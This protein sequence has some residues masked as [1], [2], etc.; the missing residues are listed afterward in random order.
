MN[1]TVFGLMSTLVLSSFSLSAQED[2]ATRATSL[3]EIVITATR[4]P[5]KVSE[6]GKVVTVIDKQEIERSNGKDMAQLLSEQAG[7][8]V[9]GAYSNPGKDKSLYLRG[10]GTDYTVILVN[11]IPVSDPSGTGGAFDV[12]MFPLEQIERIEILKGA[13]STLY[14]SDAVAGVINIITK[15]PVDKPAQLYGG[16]AA[17]SYNTFKADIG[18]NGAGEGSSY[19][20]GFTHYQTAG[21]S[22]A[23]DTTS[24]QTFDKDGFTRNAFL[25]DFDK[26]IARGLHL[27]PYF[28]YT[29]FTGDYDGGSFTDADSKYEAQLLTAG[30]QLQYSFANGSIHAYYNYDEVNR[31]FKDTY[32]EYPYVGSK[33]SVELYAHYSF[34]PHIQLLGGIHYNKQR[35]QDEAA[36]PPNPTA[37]LTSP[38]LS[39]FLRDIGGFNLELGSR[40]NK[41]SAYGNNFTYTVNPSYT[42]NDA[43]KI[44][45]NYATAFKTP[46]LQSL[47]GPF[48]SNPDLAPETSAT[49]EAGIQSTLWS[50]VLDARLVY[51]RRTIDNV[52]I[53]GP[54]F[55]LINLNKQ[56]DHGFELEP[57][58]YIGKQLKLKLYYAFVDGEVTTEQNG[59]DS[60]YSNLIRRPKHS[61]GLNAGWEVTPRFFLST[62]INYNGRRSDLYYDPITYSSQSAQLGAYTLWNAYASYQFVQNRIKLFIDLKNITNAKYNEVYGYGTQGF[63]LMGGLVIKI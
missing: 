22:E 27:K 3:D 28:R 24:G 62:Q 7:I 20:V 51:F 43:V 29:H 5:K 30:A 37:S 56:K 6:T 1:K 46:S 53:Y 15:K 31:N 35:M 48:G 49:T 11:G 63:N 50:G 41:H 19:N 61:L 33:N 60:T 52:M 14:G 2:T 36:T 4:F 17:G 26:Q 57:T 54:S 13:Q 47:Y 8:T 12:R 16:I 45:A 9:N 42:F 40:Y 38:Y 55:Q 58:I 39:F 59:K 44:F 25:A 18:I 10:A 21:I 34:V 23:Q 32:G